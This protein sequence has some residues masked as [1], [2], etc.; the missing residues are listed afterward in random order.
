MRPSTED[1]EL[2]RSGPFRTHVA[3]L[4]ALL[5]IAGAF[6]AD[7]RGRARGT[8]SGGRGRGLLPATEIDDGVGLQVFNPLVRIE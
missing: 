5:S 1:G 2:E 7:R 3:I 8:R 4:I 6:V